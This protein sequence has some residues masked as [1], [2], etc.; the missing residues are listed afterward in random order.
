MRGLFI[1]FEGIDGAGK[2]TQVARLAD[3]LLREG[4][5]VRVTRE[6]GGSPG[7][8]S[9]R[10]LLVEGEPGRWS[11]E[12]EIL[13]FAAARRDHVECVIE[14][15]LAAG[16]IVLCDRF[17]DSTRVYQSVQRPELRASVDS[18]HDM[19]IALDPDRTLILDLDL[20]LAGV[21]GEA[22]GGR[23]TRFERRGADFQ[24]RLR[25]GFRALAAEAPDRCRM[26]DG[27]GPPDAVADRVRDALRP[28]LP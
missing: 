6:P 3:R 13:L 23:E 12:T 19:L 11:P 16:E 7:A 14:P 21:R 26:V 9:I 5:R 17:I 15:A 4:H 24:R 20:E 1:T 27:A 18:I 25:D 10:T 22:R 28:L 2:S 8:E